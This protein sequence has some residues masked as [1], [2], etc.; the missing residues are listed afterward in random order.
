MELNQLGSVGEF[1]SS[2]GVLATLIFLVVE[3][4]RNNRLQLRA[5]AKQTA[6]EDVTSLQS[7]L[8]EDV[9]ELFLRGNEQG[10]SSLTPVERY[11]FDLAYVI[12][13]H[14]IE[15]AY[16]DF[17]AGT[18]PAENLVAYENSVPG[19]LSTPGGAE[20]WNQRKFWFSHQFRDDVEMLLAKRGEE[21]GFAGPTPRS[22]AETDRE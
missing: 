10:L 12:W 3:M 9:A 17:H 8:Q 14:S 20:W 6:R 18:Y 7:L 11:R 2:I 22:S 21:A 4:R 15:Q 19:F 16:A 5:A 1:I 13:L